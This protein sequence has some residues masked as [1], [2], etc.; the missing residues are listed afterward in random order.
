[1]MAYGSLVWAHSLGKTHRKGLEQV[2]RMCLLAM[3]HPMRSTPTRAME[4]VVGLLP[5]DLHCQREATKARA[6]TKTYLTDSWDG[7]T[8]IHIKPHRQWHDA[9]I[10]ELL[11]TPR[12][13]REPE[14][15]W[16]MDFEQDKLL[17]YNMHV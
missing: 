16:N 15:I 4:A 3:A 6:R 2:Q 1:M 7:N 17:A 5:L 14:W 9:L 10:K 8:E 12:D 13:K 11:Q